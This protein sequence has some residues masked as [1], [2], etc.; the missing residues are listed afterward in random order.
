MREAQI[1]KAVCAYARRRGWLTYK[2]VSPAAAGVP[3]RVFIKG[4]KTLFI[5]FKS[6]TG[7]LSDLQEAQIRR[8]RGYGAK[9]HIVNSVDQGK[10]IIDA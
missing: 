10:T 6:P 9:V 1:E 3:D 2:F 5:E 8:M 7:R 4:D